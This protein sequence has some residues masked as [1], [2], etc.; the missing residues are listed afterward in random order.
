MFTHVDVSTG[1]FGD[2]SN[3]HLNCIHG[4]VSGQDV[5]LLEGCKETRAEEALHSTCS[6]CALCLETNKRKL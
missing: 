6:Y 5:E 4:F 2:T 3:P 1:A